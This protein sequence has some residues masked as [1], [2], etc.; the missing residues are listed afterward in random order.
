ML[1]KRIK[2]VLVAGLLIFSMSGAVF[3]NEG[4][5]NWKDALQTKTVITNPD[6]DGKVKEI[7]SGFIKIKLTEVKKTVDGTEKTYIQYT[8]EW[9]SSVFHIAGINF[10][11]DNMSQTF[12][13]PTGDEWKTYTGEVEL[14]NDGEESNV[15]ESVQLTYAVN[16]T[17]SDGDG[18]PD[19]KDDTPN[20]GGEEPGPGPGEGEDPEDAREILA[21]IDT[22]EQPLDGFIDILPEIIKSRVWIKYKKELSKSNLKYKDA[23]LDSAVRIEQYVENIKKVQPKEIN[24]LAKKIKINTIYFLRD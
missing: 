12:F 22:Y 9:D 20:G 7:Q 14:R 13:G 5:A 3:A 24:K 8:V 10:N 16:N 4:V 21:E 23:L 6:L 19:F 15:L 11:E 1:N 17:D 2:S 18:V